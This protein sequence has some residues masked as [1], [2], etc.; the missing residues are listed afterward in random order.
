MS[1]LGK[2]IRQEGTVTGQKEPLS[3]RELEILQL[4]AT[5]T[6]NK[7]VARRLG[8]S[9]NT[10]KVHL[11]NIFEKLGAESRTEA[12]MIAVRE[13]WVVVPEARLPSPTEAVPPPPLPWFRRV[14]LIA[15]A[16]LAIGGT[17]LAWPRPAPSA[18]PLA[19]LLPV[20]E[21]FSPNQALR[22]DEKGGWME[23]AQMPTRRAWLG[24]AMQDRRLYAVGGEGSEGVTGATEVYNPA[25]D[26]WTRAAEKPTPAAYVGAASLEGRIFV[27]G[28]CTDDGRA[29]DVV[30][31]YDP[32]TDQWEPVAPLPRPRCAYASTVYR[33]QLYLFG[34]TDG[35]GYVATTYV[36]DPKEDRWQERTPMPQA[37]ALAAATAMDGSIYVVGGYRAGR[38]LASCVRYDPAEDAWAPCTPLRIARGG[39]GLVALGGQLYAIGGGGWGGYLGFNERYDPTNDRWEAVGTP[40]TGGWQGA[41][42]TLLDL[43]IYAVG[44]Y[45]GDYLSLTLSFEPLPFR[46]FIPA[47]ER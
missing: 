44:G 18:P 24:L 14:A 43:T 3:E 13:G 28:G 38:E 25:T 45:S 19:G 22:S 42:V 41:G 15:A 11:R 29:L 36:Y 1:P 7:E 37:Q 16:V 39:L 46:I 21:N 17:A 30:E 4:V 10:V 33:G 8:I 34:G 23:Q 6:T 26:V 5:G 2:G 12:T 31:A 27:P 20:G 40:L 35:E 47:T 32:F 9:V